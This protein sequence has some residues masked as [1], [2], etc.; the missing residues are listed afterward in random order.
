MSQESTQK[1][2]QTFVLNKK[3]KNFIR[4][5]IAILMNLVVLNLFDEYWDNVVIDSFTISLFA[6][7]LLQLM[8]KVTIAI[9]HKV[10]A[11][12]KSKTGGFMKFLKFFSLWAILFVSK[13]VILEA[14]NIAFGDKV[15]FNGAY[16]GVITFIVVVTVM[17]I[18]EE[19]L[20]RINKSL[21]K[22]VKS[23]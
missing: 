3:Q 23:D 4:Y 10:S 15:Q 12:F 2:E 1:I 7:I 9:E 8:L 11:W 6:A 5:T 14:I 17:V 18:S 16:H 22:T 13:L 21:N 19:V 20:V